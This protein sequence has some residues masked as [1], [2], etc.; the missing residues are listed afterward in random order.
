M[1]VGMHTMSAAAATL[2]VLAAQ[3]ARTS[4]EASSASKLLTLSHWP[5]CG[6]FYV[7]VTAQRTIA[8]NGFD[9]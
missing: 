2:L 6:M 5:I 7:Q 3:T 1:L 4:L 8:G 9:I